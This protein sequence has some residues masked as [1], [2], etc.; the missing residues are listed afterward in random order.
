MTD[1]LYLDLES[2]P[3]TNPDHIAEIA[4]GVT[5]P[6]SMS[7]PETIAKWEAEQK[8]EAVKEA[9]ARTS[10][11]GAYGSICSI[12]WAWND[13]Q[14]FSHL[15]SDSPGERDFLSSASDAFV[16]SRR[17]SE[18]WRSVQIVGHYVA[19]FDLRFM[20]QRAMVLGVRMPTFWPRDLKPWSKDIFDTMNAWAGA[21]GSIS[22]DKLC[23]A[24]GIPGKDGIDGSMVAQ[25]WAGGRYDEVAAY[26]RDD[27]ERVRNVHRKMMVAYGE[28]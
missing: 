18:D 7:K 25:M 26:N 19:D 11:N 24:L 3:T 2:I 5:P 13:E 17:K 15:L 9:V 16:G 10:F 21:K 28:N 14:V 27:V 6:A 22:L 23:A 4:K 12:A 20:W 8:P 1:Y